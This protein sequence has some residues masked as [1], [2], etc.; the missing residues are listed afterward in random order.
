MSIIVGA[1][2]PAIS[3]RKIAG[4]PAPTLRGALA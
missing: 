1:G 2:L 3:R 4:K